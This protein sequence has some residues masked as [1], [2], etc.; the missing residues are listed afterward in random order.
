MKWCFYIT[1]KNL[2][3]FLYEMG[4]DQEQESMLNSLGESVV[5]SL[6]NGEQFEFDYQKELNENIEFFPT[7]LI[8]NFPKGDYNELGEVKWIDWDNTE[9]LIK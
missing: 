4:S 1:K 9:F 8:E 6:S 5:E 2:I 3:H 7:D